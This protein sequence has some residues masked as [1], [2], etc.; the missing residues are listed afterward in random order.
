MFLA[1][2]LPSTPEHVTGNNLKLYSDPTDIN[3]N[4]DFDNHVEII[5]TSVEKDFQDK[6]KEC[7]NNKNEE[8]NE[9]QFEFQDINDIKYVSDVC[10]HGVLNGLESS[11]KC[12]NENTSKFN[13]NSDCHSQDTSVSLE[14]EDNIG[15]KSVK[16]KSESQDN[17]NCN[18][19]VDKDTI[20]SSSKLDSTVT[21]NETKNDDTLDTHQLKLTD[22]LSFTTFNDIGTQQLSP[23]DNTN[24]CETN[25]ISKSQN[26]EENSAQKSPNVEKEDEN[27]EHDSYATNSDTF[28]NFESIKTAIENNLGDYNNVQK[29]LHQEG[30][31]KMREDKDFDDFKTAAFESEENC[32]CSNKEEIVKSNIQSLETFSD[33]QSLNEK[34]ITP[35]EAE[36]NSN[37]EFSEANLQIKENFEKEIFDNVDDFGDFEDFKAASF[38]ISQQAENINRVEVKEDNIKNLNKE[39]IVENRESLEDV[40]VKAKEHLNKEIK[41]PHIIQNK[42]NLGNKVLDDTDD[43][44][45]FGSF[46]AFPTT[47]TTK[48]NEIK[49]DDDGFDDFEDFKSAT[50]TETK[51]SNPNEDF[52]NFDCF[53]SSTKT[54]TITNKQD[55]EKIIKDVFP[56]IKCEF[57]EWKDTDSL[58][59]GFVFKNLEE[60]TETNAISYQWVQSASQKM[61][62]RSLNIDTRNIVSINY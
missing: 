39:E 36:E 46:E 40:S 9:A 42:Q 5:D 1:F 14:S 13:H 21:S 32:E 53:A 38:E 15:S 8:K 27:Y 43:F 50:A 28:G 20:S 31:E 56:I 12:K 23:P 3:S 58:N 47:S 51:A 41:E 25:F 34:E 57:V 24:E 62:L 48:P 52:G 26:S 30:E 35:L 37:D 45:D 19:F 60:I 29:D 59:K 22:D 6:R 49:T 18:N 4:N 44:G 33:F 7:V 55:A 17:L 61:L 16:C 11:E 10:E 54:S 2:S